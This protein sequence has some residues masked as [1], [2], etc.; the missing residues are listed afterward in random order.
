MC[1]VFVFISVFML[2][3]L[4]P[5]YL[6]GAQ[7]LTIGLTEQDNPFIL[8][9]QIDSEEADSTIHFYENNLLFS[10]EVRAKGDVELTDDDRA[11]KSIPHGG[12]VII[13]D[14]NWFTYR[15]L[16]VRPGASGP[17]VSFFVQGHPHEFDE[18]ASYWLA[19]RLPEI[20][21]K[22]GLGARQR[23]ERIIRE[24]GVASAI[25]EIGEARSDRAIQTY[26][27]IIASYPDTDPL[28]LERLIRTVAEE[29][30]S[31]RRLS[32]I[33]V[34][35]ADK[36]PGDSLVTRSL[37]IAVEN[38]S[39]SSKQGETLEAIA[40]HRRLDE[41]SAVAMSRIIEGISSS[42]VQAEALL[43]MLKHA[44]VT[45]EVGLSYLA[46]VQGVSS[47]SKQ[48]SALIGLMQSK[49]T[50][51]AVWMKILEITQ[52]ISSSSVQAEVLASFADG[53]PNEE[54]LLMTYI[55]T[56]RFISS[57]AAQ[58]EALKALLRKEGLAQHVVEET[59]RFADAEISSSSISRSVSDEAKNLLMQSGRRQP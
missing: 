53:C 45:K 34:R 10:V 26:A 30:S 24:D 20:A 9:G 39:S 7:T 21:R 19:S 16:E 46:V 43:M 51:L 11:F 2:E 25:R 8:L 12:M 37:I 36:H 6:N 29:I 31:S 52:G 17:E 55:S 48:G 3:A 18:E 22:S 49:P 1:K 13:R 27:N 5:A 42:S 59:I 57:S 14:R 40:Q 23:I 58:G 32:A 4:R 38:I 56:V 54:D 41:N 33:L 28:L 50:S 35:L 47:S 15:E 44:V